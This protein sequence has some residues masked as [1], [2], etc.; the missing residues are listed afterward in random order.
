MTEIINK[1]QRGNTGSMGVTLS[2][3]RILRTS[4]TKAKEVET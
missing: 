2:M 4:A 3:N 1:K